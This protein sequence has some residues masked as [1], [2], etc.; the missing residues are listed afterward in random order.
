[1]DTTRL[2][3]V[4]EDRHILSKAQKSQGL[5]QSWILLKPQHHNI[6]DL[7]TYLTHIFD[8]HHSCPNGIILSMDGFVL[9]PFESTCILKDKDVIS[10][11]RKGGMSSEIVDKS[12]RENLIEQ[13]EIVEKQP[14]LNCM[15][16]LANGEFEKETGNFE[17][18]PEEDED[19]VSGDTL[20][21]DN[22]F[23][24]NVLSKKRKASK[25]LQSSRKKKRTMVPQDIEND[26]Q[27]DQNESC[28]ND[29]L[30]RGKSIEKEKVSIVKSKPKRV[31]TPRS[32]ER[33]NDIAEPLPNSKRFG[34]LQENGA[35]CVDA[36]HTPDGTK[37]VPSRSARRKKT[38]RQWLR[39]IKRIEKEL[40]ASNLQLC[41][42]QSP[43]KH[44][45]K[46]SIE[47]E[48]QSQNGEA[49]DEI[50][51]I[52][53]RPGHIRFEPLGKDRAVQQSQVSVETFQWNGITSKKKGQKWGKENFQSNRRN[54][55]KDSNKE[56]SEMMAV[57]EVKPSNDPL[58]FDRLPPLT[59]FPKVG[60]TS[61]CDPISHTILLTPVPEYPLIFEKQL[62]GDA[63]VQPPDNSL[64]REDGSLE[65]DFSTLVDVRIVKH[66]NSVPAKVET[67]WVNDRP[68]RNEVAIST[69]ARSN[70]YKRKHVPK[71]GNKVNAQSPN[72]T[73]ALPIE[74]NGW[75]NKN[76]WHERM[77]NNSLE[78]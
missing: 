75:S 59:S 46:D 12:D 72:S 11:K 49:D 56:C 24:D 48:E 50:V 9:P 28:P 62:D 73:N 64:Y 19:N 43:E 15:P 31:S 18:E 34:K 69:V 22:S 14:V 65:I 30:H 37:K 41:E 20:H 6:S 51:P 17:S 39:E 53:I 29:V 36:P 38:K 13:E 55:Y 7:S 78:K 52:V 2:C 44:M 42:R 61:R 26:F 25:K 27:T 47:H 35:G 16:L 4:F 74:E 54:G 21:V 3:V 77:I 66:G 63:W 45:P 67:G 40:V 57:E 71:K 23:G 8:V 5:N 10:V 68:V 76:S 58:N 32:A 70:N 60:K 33:N 1:M